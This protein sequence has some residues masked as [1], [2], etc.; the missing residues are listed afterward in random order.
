MIQT[1]GPIRSHARDSYASS[2]VTNNPNLFACDDPSLVAQY[3]QNYPPLQPT[4]VLGVQPSTTGEEMLYPE[5][6]SRSQYLHNVENPNAAGLAMQV[7]PQL[8]EPSDTERAMAAAVAS[9]VH[10]PPLSQ[11][12][13]FPGMGSRYDML[14]S[15]ADPDSLM[16][17]GPEVLDTQGRSNFGVG[18]NP[19][20]RTPSARRGPF[21]DHDQREKTAHTRRIGS[22]I[23]CRMQRI[24]VR[25]PVHASN[26]RVLNWAP[27]T[28]E[29]NA[30]AIWIRR[31]RRVLAS[32]AK[33]WQLTEFGV[34][35]VYAGR[36]QT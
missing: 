11:H 32:V 18:Y 25:S 17:A 6:P 7:A 34:S 15:Y 1:S 19:H 14:H 21:K 33:R 31:T 28:D 2:E 36:S 10:S 12:A 30:S 9:D 29:M 26:S 5:S 13:T 16:S 24:R 8:T 4:R 35:H 20:Q 3:L 27:Q 23:R 22:C